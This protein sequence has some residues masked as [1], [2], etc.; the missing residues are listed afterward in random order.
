LIVS[1]VVPVVASLTHRVSRNVIRHSSA[2]RIGAH[3]AGSEVNAAKDAR[4]S[5]F[6]YCVRET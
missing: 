2:E 5:N 6:R 3:A 1:V 4:I